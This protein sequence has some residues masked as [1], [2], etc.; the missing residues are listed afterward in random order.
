MRMNQIDKTYSQLG[1]HNL[2]TRTFLAAQPRSGQ[3]HGLP[4]V[5]RGP[6]CCEVI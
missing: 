3:L 2:T 6:G 1:N 5:L 4:G